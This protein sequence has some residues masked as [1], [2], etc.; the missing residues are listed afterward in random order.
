MNQILLLYMLLCTYDNNSNL[1]GKL[2]T[3]RVKDY[4]YIKLDLLNLIISW[5]SAENVSKQRIWKMTI[6]KLNFSQTI[7]ASTLSFD[8]ETEIVGRL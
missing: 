1:E 6:G 7:E 3:F 4:E 8:P 2:A 5:R